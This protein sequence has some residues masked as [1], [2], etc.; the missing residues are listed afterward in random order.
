MAVVGAATTAHH[1]EPRQPLLQPGVLRAE[2]GRIA[3][4]EFGGVVQ[5]GMALAG[6]GR[7]EVASCSV[8]RGS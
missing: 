4:I 1:I 2:F 8:S 7:F 3:D 5:L 6:A